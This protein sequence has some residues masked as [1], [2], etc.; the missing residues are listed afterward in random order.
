MI[1]TPGRLKAFIENGLVNLS[2]V[3][4]LTLDEADSMVDMGFIDDIR[5]IRSSIIEAKQIAQ[6]A[7]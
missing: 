2:Y 7:Q 1:A 4:A 5:M 3:V 6:A